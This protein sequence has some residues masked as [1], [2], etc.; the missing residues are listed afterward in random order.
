MR[1]R[2]LERMDRDELEE[3][4]AEAWL[5]RAQKRVAKA[6]LAEHGVDEAPG[7]S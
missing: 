1:I 2:D 7:Q 3:L 6:W 5:A 4:V